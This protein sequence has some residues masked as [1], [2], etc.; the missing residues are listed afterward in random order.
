[1]CVKNKDPTREGSSAQPTAGLRSV[2]QGH[3]FPDD[4]P[5]VYVTLKFCIYLHVI[6][7]EH[8]NSG[9]ANE[10][11]CSH[12][13]HKV[14]GEGTEWCILIDCTAVVQD[15]GNEPF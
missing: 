14:L 11:E 2:L 4:R 6:R 13:V 9:T 3:R 8:H 12:K 7:N 5:F 10:L 1:M 15:Q